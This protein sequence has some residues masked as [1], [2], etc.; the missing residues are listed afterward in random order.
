[1]KNKIVCN[2]VEHKTPQGI[3][4]EGKDIV[5][6]RIE[7]AKVDGDGSAIIDPDTGRP[8]WTGKTLEWSIKVGETVELPAY[9][10]DILLKTYDWLEEV[11]E[12]PKEEPKEAK[13]REAGKIICKWCGQSF[14]SEVNL[15]VHVGAKHPEKLI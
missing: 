3:T 5:D 13:K 2:P 14:R 9:V 10:A 8:K 11:K 7:E 6:Y 1:M 4:L 15:G 12:K